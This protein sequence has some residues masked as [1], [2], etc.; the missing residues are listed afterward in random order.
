MTGLNEHTAEQVTDAKR[1][2][3]TELPTTACA[4]HVAQ[5]GY[6]TLRD[7]NLEVVSWDDLTDENVKKELLEEAED[8]RRLNRGE[9]ASISSFRLQ[10]GTDRKSGVSSWEVRFPMG[11]KL[12]EHRS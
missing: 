5:D 4:I 1:N 9:N 12:K 7:I 2:E 8:M 6:I 3:K 11:M 10:Y